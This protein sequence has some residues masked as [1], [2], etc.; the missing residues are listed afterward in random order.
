VQDPSLQDLVSHRDPSIANT[1]NKAA[2]H[3]PS[4][5]TKEPVQTLLQSLVVER[6]GLPD[7]DDRLSALDA[8]IIPLTN[9]VGA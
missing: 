6:S 2:L 5:R 9:L 1:A 3:M 4:E 8:S 7:K